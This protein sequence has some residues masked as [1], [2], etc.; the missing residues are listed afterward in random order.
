MAST[1][2]TAI[3]PPESPSSSALSPGIPR[4]A[5]SDVLFFLLLRLRHD[6][7]PKKTGARSR[8]QRGLAPH[9][10]RPIGIQVRGFR[11]ALN[12]TT[13]TQVHKLPTLPPPVAAFLFGVFNLR[14]SPIFII[15]TLPPPSL[16]SRT[17][18]SKKE[19]SVASFA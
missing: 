7:S 11:A 8:S 12:I 17:P 10:N 16:C 4:V 9:W 14:Y 6:G 18:S 19:V 5:P 13:G 15:S 3:R 2:S 1:A